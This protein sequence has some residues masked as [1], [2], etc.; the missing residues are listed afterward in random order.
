MSAT[1]STMTAGFMSAERG[2]CW[3]LCP[4][5]ARGRGM[6]A[7]WADAAVRAHHARDG[8]ERRKIWPITVRPSSLDLTMG[9]I[10]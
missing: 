1:G 6:G 4:R 5:R 9:T 3:L 8:W 2:G 7:D 10:C